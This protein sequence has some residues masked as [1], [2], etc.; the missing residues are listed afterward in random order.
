MI[1][2]YLRII[3]KIRPTK[4]EPRAVIFYHGHT[5]YFRGAKIVFVILRQRNLRTQNSHVKQI[6]II[7]R[8]HLRA[9]Y[10]IRIIVM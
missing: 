7:K 1:I 2:I 5:N 9:I 6:A 4:C 3:Y 10:T 8:K